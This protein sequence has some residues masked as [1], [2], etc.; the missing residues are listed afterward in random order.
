MSAIATAFSGPQFPLLPDDRARYY[1]N[2]DNRLQFV[3]PDGRV[4]NFPIV[5][6]TSLFSMM[7]EVLKVPV[8]SEV[9]MYLSDTGD[10]RFVF[11]I[12]W[13]EEDFTD[14]W[15]YTPATLPPMFK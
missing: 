14:L 9:T 4:R 8:D 11:G 7:R 1:A 13:D 5:V 3:Y 2:V 10:R 6:H 12:M 15:Y